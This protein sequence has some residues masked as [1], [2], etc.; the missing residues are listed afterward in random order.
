VQLPDGK[1]NS[2]LW[3]HC[4]NAV[5]KLSVPVSVL[6]A[7][8]AFVPC[9]YVDPYAVSAPGY[10]GYVTKARFDVVYRAEFLSG[11]ANGRLARVMTGSMHY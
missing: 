6:P 2:S 4:K 11:R 8:K 1:P 10:E 9:V 7:L 3:L 5:C